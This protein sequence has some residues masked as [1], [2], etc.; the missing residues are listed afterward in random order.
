M[1]PIA[2]LWLTLPLAAST[3]PE[4]AVHEKV[5]GMMRASEGDVVFTD[6]YN[7]PISD[8]ERE[9]ASRL[10]EVFFAI[11]E[12]LRTEYRA[13]GQLPTLEAIAGSFGI[14]AEAADLLLEVM[15]SDSRMPELL[16]R[17]PASGALISLDI[18][19]IDRF[20]ERRGSALELSG[21][22]GRE[23]PAFDYVTLDGREGNVTELRGR[24]VLLYLWLTRFPVCRRN[25]PVMAELQALFGERVAFLGLN[26]DEALGLEVRGEE[27][28]AWLEDNGIRYT[29]ATLD[30]A[31]RESLGN[32]N[33]F[34][35]F[36]LV[37]AEGR[38][39]G[40]ALN[41]QDL[42]SLSARLKPLLTE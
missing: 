12:L 27:R 6:L 1:A 5:R 40:L 20:V 19:A 21:W 22:R 2:V 26:A 35:T 8:E 14:S 13:T 41:F 16:T 31:T 18:E 42:E 17:D 23:L 7:G 9:Y 36:F 32:P 3:P 30:H 33:I 28:R 15:T 39:Q 10:Y 4:A 38:V 25:T 29:N 11:P 37:D 34:P 24:P